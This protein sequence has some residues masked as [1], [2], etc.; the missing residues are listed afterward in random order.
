MEN[1]IEA[2]LQEVEDLL[3]ELTEARDSGSN[4]AAIAESIFSI[5]TTRQKQDL[6]E[7]V[8]RRMPLSH[9]EITQLRN[10]LIERFATEEFAMEV[11]ARLKHALSEELA[12]AAIEIAQNTC[13]AYINRHVD[14]LDKDFKMHL[15]IFFKSLPPLQQS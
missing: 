5:L 11:K 12:T 8:A 3:A 9:P 10:Q 6:L 14:E 15:A 4:H 13:A 7:A 2:K 1:A